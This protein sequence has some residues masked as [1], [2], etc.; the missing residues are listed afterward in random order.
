M[1]SDSEVMVSVALCTYNGQRYISQQLDSILTQSC[2]PD[3]VVISDDDSSDST[4]DILRKY[5]QR[6]PEIIKLNSNSNNMGITKNFEKCIKLCN[7]ELIA[8]SDQDDIWKEKKLEKQV[9]SIKKHDATLVFHDSEISDENL[10]PI[11]SRWDSISY[12]SGTARKPESAIRKLCKINYVTG[13]TIMFDSSLREYITPIPESWMHDYYIAIN[14][15]LFGRLYD[16]DEK[17]HFWRQH[18]NQHTPIPPTSYAQRVIN[19]IQSGF[20]HVNYEEEASKWADLLTI[21]NNINSSKFSIEKSMA[22][23]Y[24]C[25]K[26]DY[27]KNKSKIYSPNE[28][29]ISKLGSIKFNYINNLYGSLAP[30][31][32]RLHLAKDTAAIIVTPFCT[33]RGSNL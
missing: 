13:G 10:N 3:E 30:L 5:K 17:L 25:D 6:Y 9:K 28:S 16:I 32:T 15:A 7:G 31:P 4:L 20:C 14:A 2:P 27:Y 29:I 8:L 22:C 23:D 12:N 18:Q 33:E 26:Y 11:G 24:I 21:M 1:T 19:G